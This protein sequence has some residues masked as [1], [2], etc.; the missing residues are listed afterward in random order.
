MGGPILKD[1][2][3]FFGSLI[4]STRAPARRPPL[5]LPSLPPRPTEFSSCN[6]R[7]PNNP[8]VSALAAIGPASSKVGNLTFGTPTTV[9][10]LGQ[11]IEFAT[12]RRTIA[13]PFNDYEG[14]GRVDYQ[15]ARTRPYFR[16]V[17]L[18]EYGQRSV[19][20]FFPPYEVVTGGFV[21]VPGTS[22]Y[23]GIDW[24]HTFNDHFLNQARY[25]Y[26]RSTTS[27]EGGGFANCT[28]A[29]ILTGCPIRVDFNDGQTL[30]LGE[31]PAWPQGRI[32]R[33][34]QVQD[35]ISWQ[36]GKHFLKLGGEY[37][38]YPESDTGLPNVNGDLRFDN[39]GEYINTAPTVTLYAEGPAAYNL[40]F[41]YGAVYLQDDWKASGKSHL[42]SRASLRDPEPAAE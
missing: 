41:N 5:L 28:S 22:N 34:H 23:V 36:A 8:A 3:W 39:F 35:N 32:V 11:P 29:A 2:L 10:V 37:N 26:A 38:H 18:S 17:H 42:E 33:S 7:F 4:L 40:V 24:A 19:I 13:S 20:N 12:A 9:D 14:T 6:R 31:N 25:S 30:S 27:F 1:K 16:P 21:S 15:F